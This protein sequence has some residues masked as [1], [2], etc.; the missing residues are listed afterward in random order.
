MGNG[1]NNIISML[2]HFLVT[3]TFEEAHLHVDNCLDHNKNCYVP[4]M[5]Y[6]VWPEQIHHPVLPDRGTHQ[7]FARLVWCFSLLKQAY[8]WTRIGCLDDIVW[9]V[10]SLAAVNHAQLVGTQNGKVLVPTYDWATFFDQPFQQL[11]LK[12]IKSM[13]HMTFTSSKLGYVIVKDSVDAP[14]RSC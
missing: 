12:G 1:T 7:V 4:C 5:A 10:K 11:A 2:H 8:K 14:E 9:V 13:H 3:H 6:L